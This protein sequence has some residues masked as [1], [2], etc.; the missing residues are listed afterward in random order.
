[1]SSCP[2]AAL[3]V[4]ASAVLLVLTAPWFLLIAIAI[5]LNSAGPV[6]HRA[7]RVGR[8]GR[9]FLL[10]KFRSMRVNAAA[11]GPGITPRG[12]D[13]V[14]TAGRV[15]R[16]SKLDELPQLFNV[17]KGEMSL[18]GPRPEDPRYV[19]L[20][21]AEQRRV[22]A[23]RLGITSV[24]SVEYRNEEEHL[25]GTNWERDHVELIMPRKLVQDLELAEHPFLARNLR[26]L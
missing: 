22:L 19:A 11:T 7:R 9:P 13:R 21:S 15:L 16:H 24:A 14:T 26:V 17:L 23:V 12:D 8:H 25:V 4:A 20:Y 1:V 18:V 5:K 2:S 3:D 10:L 6:L